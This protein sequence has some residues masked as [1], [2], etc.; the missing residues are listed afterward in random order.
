MIPVAV[1]FKMEAVLVNYSTLK[2]VFVFVGKPKPK[3]IIP[4]FDKEIAGSQKASTQS[5]R[6]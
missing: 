1:T 6:F 5:P 3:S 4:G 2:Y